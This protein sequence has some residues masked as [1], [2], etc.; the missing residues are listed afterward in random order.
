MDNGYDPGAAAELLKLSATDYICFRRRRRSN[1]TSEETD[2]GSES[3]RSCVSVASAPATPTLARLS[4]S[5]TSNRQRHGV[6]TLQ[7]GCIECCF[8]LAHLPHI[9]IA[10][11][12][13]RP[14]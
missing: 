9:E 5:N 7:V 2:D 14:S 1:T 4:N 13:K 6:D 3:V 10:Q 11:C 8:H 12:M